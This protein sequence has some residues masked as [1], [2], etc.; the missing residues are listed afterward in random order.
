MG[1]GGVDPARRRQRDEVVGEVDEDVHEVPVPDGVGVGVGPALDPD[2]VLVPALEVVA[3]Q[4][5]PP[6]RQ[7]PGGGGGERDGGFVEREVEGVEV[8]PGLEGVEGGDWVGDGGG[9]LRG[10][11]WRLP[12]PALFLGG[13]GVRLVGHGND[14]VEEAE[15]REEEA[16]EE[17]EWRKEQPPEGGENSATTSDATEQHP[18]DGT[19][20]VVVR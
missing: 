5:P 3:H 4:K 7:N 11:E 6:R 18:G 12:W 19:F 1:V 13:P 14:S 15:G 10:V 9:G 17:A 20:D 8:R 16:P 2:V